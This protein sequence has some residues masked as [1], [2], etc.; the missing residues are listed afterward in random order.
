[1]A[2]HCST[3]FQQILR[4]AD[5]GLAAASWSIVCDVS[6]LAKQ[7]QMPF[8]MQG[9]W[10]F[11]PEQLSATYWFSSLDAVILAPTVPTCSNDHVGRTIDFFVVHQSLQY[12]ATVGV[13]SQVVTEPHKP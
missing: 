8:I 1:M 11:T 3:K 5:I 10:Q 2:C 6:S 7:F 4:S 12:Q 9:D 13:L